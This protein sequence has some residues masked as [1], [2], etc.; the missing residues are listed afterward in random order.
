MCYYI[1]VN[2]R[3]SPRKPET[4][5]RRET[6]QKEITS[7][8]N[9]YLKEL[10]RLRKNPT[11]EYFFLEGTR[12]VEELPADCIKEVFTADFE[13]HKP[14]LETLPDPIPV[15]RLSPA[16]MAKICT[17]KSPQT[18][19]CTVTRKN[20]PRP[21]KLVLL[22]G[23]Q[24]PGNVGTVIRTAYAFGF[25]VLLS[26]GCANPWSE[27]VLMST[28]GA[29]RNCYIEEVT[30]LAATAKG[31]KEEGFTLFAT[32]LDD[33]AIPP[34][35][36]EYGK[37]RAVIIGNEGK[38]ISA[39]VLAAAHKTVYIPMENPINSLNAASAASIMIYR[40]K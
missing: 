33:R 37:K 36:M 12:F 20:P 10:C 19:A 17:A 26:P 35:A 2:F 39:E 11:G 9:P 38:G 30:D 34:E 25:G 16:A 7:A 23:V 21:E 18:I 22:D 5:E 15:Y 40:M 24:D 31:L 13:K 4:E 27:K 28:A 8:K 32:A 14:F 1:V 6:V 29:F 3:F